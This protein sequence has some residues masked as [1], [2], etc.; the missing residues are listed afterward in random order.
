MEIAERRRQQ[1]ERAQELERL[2]QAS[3][4]EIH[5]AE[6][7]AN[8]AQGGLKS[9][10]AAVAWWTGEKGIEVTGTLARVDCLTVSLKLTIARANGAN[11]VVLVRDPKNIAV[12][13]ADQATF[14][15]GS[16]RPAPRIVLEHNGKADAAFGTAGDVLVVEVP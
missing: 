7:A 13:G 10:T 5:A 8:A 11:A 12:R 2:K 14:A 9:G 6:D 15:C 16:P 4:A 1:D 3:A